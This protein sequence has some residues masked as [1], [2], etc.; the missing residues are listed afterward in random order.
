MQTPLSLPQSPSLVETDPPSRKQAQRWAGKSRDYGLPET[1]VFSGPLSYVKPW[2]CW[3]HKTAL[4]RYDEILKSHP[5][6]RFSP[7]LLPR[8]RQALREPPASPDYRW[9][10]GGTAGFQV[11]QLLSSSHISQ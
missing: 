10:E 7:V 5:A 6:T 3:G 8:L 9:G 4:A 11:T 1:S 2:G